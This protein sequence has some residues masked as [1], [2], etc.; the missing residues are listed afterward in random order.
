MINDD[1]LIAIREALGTEF[2]WN[3]H[4]DKQAIAKFAN[5]TA[6]IL[7]TKEIPEAFA[8]GYLCAGGDTK[9]A[10]D[11]SQQFL[12]ACKADCDAKIPESIGV[13]A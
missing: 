7:L 5:I 1:L 6:N 3:H 4:M 8:A 10:L 11:Q 2:C 9:E 12:K 13:E